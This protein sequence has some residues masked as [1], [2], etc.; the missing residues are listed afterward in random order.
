M[1]ARSLLKVA[2]TLSMLLGVIG[3]CI[4]LWVSSKSGVGPGAALEL[5]VCI[6]MVGVGYVAFTEDTE[7]R[8]N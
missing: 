1:N 2:G 3:F 4:V 6:V 7:V 8:R 5:V